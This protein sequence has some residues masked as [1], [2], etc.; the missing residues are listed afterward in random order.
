[1]NADP[2]SHEASVRA[3]LQALLALAQIDTELPSRAALDDIS[4]LERWR[5]A[6]QATLSNASLALYT[7]LSEARVHP[8]IVPM[9]DSLCR[10]CYV[11]VPALTSAKI[12]AG[13]DL[14][15]C[16][17]CGRFLYSPEWLNAGPR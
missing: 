10:G 8:V 6:A 2:S 12:R 3:Q 15:A 1:M 7:S 9:V 13:A 17:S 4:V 5:R 16:P 14:E 11:E